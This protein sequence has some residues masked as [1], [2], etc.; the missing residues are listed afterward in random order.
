MSAL[1][2][3][4]LNA[5][6]AD[7]PSAGLARLAQ[8]DLDTLESAL[9]LAA[10]ALDQAEL[11]PQAARRW[12]D[13]AAALDSTGNAGLQGRVAYAQARLA[14]VAGDLA[15][16]EANLRL[17]QQRWL[18]AGDRAGLARSY[19]GLTQ[20]LTVTGRYA[21]AEQAVRLLLAEVTGANAAQSDPQGDLHIFGQIN[22]G[23][24]LRYQDR[25]T[26]ALDAYDQALSL[27][28]G[29]E[30]TQDLAHVQVNRATCLMFTDR[31]VAA[32]G[33]LTAAL[34]LLDPGDDP[35]NRGRAHTNLGSL[36][37]RTGQYAAA[38]AHFDRAAADLLGDALGEPP[39]ATLRQADVLL[40]DRANAY[41]ALNLLPE[42][43]SALD[44][45]V[46][47]FL[48]GENGANPGQPYELGQTLYLR[49]LVHIRQDALAL[50][51]LDLVQAGALFARLG[52]GHWTNRT[53][54][55][56]AGLDVRLGESAEAAT[57]LDGLMAG[58]AWDLVALA[59]ARLLRA[60]LALTLGTPLTAQ[61]LL[62]AVQSDLDAGPP[63]PLFPH[64][65]MALAHTQGQL[66]QAQG[67]WVGA[68]AHFQTAVSLLENQR[69]SLPLEEVRTAFLDD[70][71]IL[72]RDLVLSLLDAPDP[73][74]AQLAHVFAVI[75]Q[76][77]SRALLERLLAA[78]ED[79]PAAGDEAIVQRRDQVRQQLTWIYN[80]ILGEG[81][82]RKLTMPLT[83]QL[84][85]LERTLK[86][87]AWRT[88]P[89]LA[90]AQPADLAAL[91]ASL[92]GDQ[93][94]IVYF[95]ADPGSKTGDVGEVMAFVVGSDRVELVR[96]LCTPAQ[97]QAAQADL[98]FHLSRA[99]LGADY[100]SRHAVRLQTGLQGSLHHLYRL[101]IAPL[102]PLLWAARL[103]VIPHGPL[104]LL[105][106]H[107]LWDGADYLLAR[108]EMAYAPSASL[109]VHCAAA[110]S[111][112]PQASLAGLA[113]TDASIPQAR[114]EAQT[115]A[116]HFVQAQLF[117]DEAAGRAGLRQAAA[118][119][120]VLHIAT[121]GLFRP[122]NP[123]FS[124]LKLADGWLDVREIYRLPLSAGLV[125]LSACESGVG[126]VQGGDE[127]IGLARGFLGAGA[128]SLVVSLWN[129][130]DAGVVELMDAFYRHLTGEP[131]LRPAAALAVAQRQAAR[132]GQHPYFW[133]PFIAIG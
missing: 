12:L 51:R 86:G 111:L 75:E 88:S 69:I 84:Q 56:L 115:V 124:A 22:L 89:L 87:L 72:Y 125:V 59:E 46:A 57:R 93:Q 26:A 130:H 110:P 102:D 16:A 61:T 96:Q 133:A 27:L 65:R 101:L 121:H 113:I 11:R 99:E 120:D 66:A 40:L 3:D 55:A 112:P 37:L 50:A 13:L 52:N 79:E 85:R 31:P 70:K 9:A 58:P 14:L 83:R 128:A 91:Q 97:L 28:A 122:D 32:A 117:L 64:L 17:A 131:G 106:F 47:L 104:H 34:A 68:R 116:A 126:R 80:Q 77:R 73:T 42:A 18:S 108:F 8:A 118:Q 100:L 98:R 67:D 30:P 35:V 1:L 78:V 21:Q 5:L 82:S 95:V 123:F 45:C 10:L 43:L 103:L 71:S 48:P 92:A 76:A 19:L 36:H 81:G 6:A 38:L 90:Q 53:G 94:A 7:T 15:E 114:Q 60:R 105:P 41:L 132:A 20:I 33:A 62:S 74:S 129:V 109:A 25:H 39:P 23:N 24:L 44:Q 54:L 49:G 4:L 107:A 2:P 63:P 127:V 29:D 119:A